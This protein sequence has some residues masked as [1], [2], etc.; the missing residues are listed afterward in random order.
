M[1]GGDPAGRPASRTIA[2]VEPVPGQDK[3]LRLVAD[4]APLAASP[5]ANISLVIEV[6]QR[7]KGFLLGEGTVLFV[8]PGIQRMRVGAYVVDTSNAQGW[9]KLQVRGPGQP[10]TV[11]EGGARISSGR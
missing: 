7:D 9:S 3:S 11:I 4:S 10:L 8:R 2:I 5:Y 1:V 6:D